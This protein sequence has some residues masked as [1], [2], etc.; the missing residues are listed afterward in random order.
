MSVS[1]AE[2]QELA[3]YVQHALSKDPALRADIMTLAWCTYQVQR[4]YDYV[5]AGGSFTKQQK[6]DKLVEVIRPLVRRQPAR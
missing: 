2:L 3:K 6:M 5:C 4:H 1:G